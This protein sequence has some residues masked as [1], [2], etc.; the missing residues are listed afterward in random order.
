M[1]TC[2]RGERL[3]LPISMDSKD[4][5]PISCLV[6][7]VLQITDDPITVDGRFYTRHFGDDCFFHAVYFPVRSF[8]G[9]LNLQRAFPCHLITSFADI[10]LIL[11][12]GIRGHVRVF[13]ELPL[14]ALFSHSTLFSQ[15]SPHLLLQIR[16][17]LKGENRS[18]CTQEI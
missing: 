6:L 13:C 5:S 7:E 8:V 12:I 1:I 16:F 9:S 10:L 15:I 17:V 11:G 14:S 4:N 18:L 3:L 2:I